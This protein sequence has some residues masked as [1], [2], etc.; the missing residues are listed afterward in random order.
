M[1]RLVRTDL[2]TAVSRGGKAAWRREKVEEKDV[3]RGE[4]TE[5]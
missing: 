5:P 1:Q 3:E 4:S 2:R